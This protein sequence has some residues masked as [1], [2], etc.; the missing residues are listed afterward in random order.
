[1]A[2]KTIFVSFDYKNDKHYKLLLQAWNSH[3]DFEFNFNDQSITSP[4]NSVDQNL[5]K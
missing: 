1:M 3:P 5:K 2:K 4:I